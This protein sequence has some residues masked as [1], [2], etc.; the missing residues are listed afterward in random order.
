[1]ETRLKVYQKILSVIYIFLIGFFAILCLQS[2][3]DSGVLS[4]RF[5]EMFA[6]LFGITNNEELGRYIRKLIGHFGFFC[7]FGTVSSLFYLTFVS[8]KVWLRIL[9]SVT[10]GF[11][12][13]VIT[14][15]VLQ[16]IAVDR[17]P[18]V[19]YV[20]LDYSVFIS[21][22]IITYLIYFAYTY[23]QNKDLYYNLKA[24]K[25]YIITTGTIY[26]LLLIGYI[27]LSFLTGKSSSQVSSSVSQVVIDVTPGAGSKTVSQSDTTTQMFMR[28]LIGHFGYFFILSASSFLFYFGLRGLKN[29]WKYLIHIVSG[30]GFAIITE[31]V[32]QNIISTRTASF[33]DVLIDSTGFI[34]MTLVFLLIVYST[35]LILED[36]YDSF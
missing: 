6:N 9:I 13:I 11:I 20:L 8:K 27:I 17:G 4:G 5:S 31:Y 29:K 36:K 24:R 15:F 18:S 25:I 19:N 3:N 26:G 28:K 12:Y 2:G 10:T 21:L 34:T 16:N 30:I 1:M 7:L 33:N 35:K 14:E 23:I 22:S 32:I